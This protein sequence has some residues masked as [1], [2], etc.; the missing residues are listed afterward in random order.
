MKVS[1]WIALALA[2]TG[3]VQTPFIIPEVVSQVSADHRLI[4]GYV[5][6]FVMRF[7]L[8]WMFA[9]IWWK[10]RTSAAANRGNAKPKS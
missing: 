6:G 3:L 10:T 2:I 4:P 9:T 1:R 5:V 8:I 7:L